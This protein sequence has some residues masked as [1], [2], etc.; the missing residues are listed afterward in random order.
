MLKH[1]AVGIVIEGRNLPYNHVEGSKKLF[2]I[3]IFRS[4]SLLKSTKPCKSFSFGGRDVPIGG[5]GCHAFQFFF[6][7]ARKLVK[8][9]HTAR[10][11]ATV[12]SATFLS[13][14]SW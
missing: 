12:F 1:I 6:K 7:F 4:I 14:N 8:V 2:D 3:Y 11:V 10:E 13:N 9:G 5:V